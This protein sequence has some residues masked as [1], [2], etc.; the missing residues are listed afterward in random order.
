MKTF[1]GSGFAGTAP[2]GGVSLL[3]LPEGAVFT[4]G[5]QSSPA[6]GYSQG[7]VFETGTGRVYASGEAAMFSANL[8]PPVAGM[9]TV[10]PDHN[11]QFLLNIMHWF[12][13]LL[14]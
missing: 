7:M 6:A 4:V 3:T 9:Q 1:L 13:G 12:D 2:P 8:G 5:G 11:Q 14:D 10:P